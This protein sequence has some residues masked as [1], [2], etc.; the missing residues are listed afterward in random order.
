MAT[1][2]WPTTP[3]EHQAQHPT[4]TRPRWRAPARP[5]R[6]DLDSSTDDES[7]PSGQ[8]D[9]FRIIT[10]DPAFRFDGLL[11]AAALANTPDQYESVIDL[12]YELMPPASPHHANRLASAL[13]L[14]PEAGR[15]LLDP[16]SLAG[17][18]SDWIRAL[19]AGLWCTAD[20]QPPQVG[21]RCRP[22]RESA[23]QPGSSPARQ[24]A[25]RGPAKQPRTRY[26][27]LRPRRPEGSR[28]R[29]TAFAQPDVR[30]RAPPG[31][32][33]LPTVTGI[34]AARR[35]PL[36]RMAGRESIPLRWWPSP[37]RS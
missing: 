8:L 4:L 33:G 30:L 29:A 10:G 21:G 25:V 31:P 13:S 12:A 28:L 24:A 9:R 18:E 23:P 15:A 20:G 27:P 35:A 3:A 11:A 32:A 1:A 2:C 37:S 16:R 17:H 6:G 14:L 5:A 26:P 22:V 34:S 19:A 36:A 7:L